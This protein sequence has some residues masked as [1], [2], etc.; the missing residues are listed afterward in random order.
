MTGE[1]PP[2]HGCSQ[3][4]QTNTFG[5]FFCCYYLLEK[6][7]KASD[8]ITASYE[9]KKEFTSQ[10]IFGQTIQGKQGLAISLV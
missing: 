10:Y 8:K 9:G 1:C 3:G 4:S 2:S 6:T 5:L 7:L